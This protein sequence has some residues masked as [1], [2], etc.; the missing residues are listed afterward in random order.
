[1]DYLRKN[2]LG[3]SKRE[4]TPAV[5]REGSPISDIDDTALGTD[6]A[7]DAAIQAVLNARNSAGAATT[8]TQ[9]APA[10]A[11]GDRDATMEDTT[12]AQT[13]PVETQQQGNEE[14]VDELMDDD[15]VPLAKRREREQGP[16]TPDVEAAPKD[17]DRAATSAG[18][19]GDAS[20]TIAVPSNAANNTVTDLVLRNKNI[21]P[22]SVPAPLPL[23]VV[24]S[25]QHRAKIGQQLEQQANGTTSTTNDVATSSLAVNNNESAPKDELAGTNVNPDNGASATT[26]AATYVDNGAADV[27]L[28]LGRPITTGAN[29]DDDDDMRIVSTN[30]V[31]RLPLPP[32]E[33]PAITIIL[34]DANNYQVRFKCKPDTK[35]IKLFEA[36][37][38][39]FQCNLDHIRFISQNGIQLPKR[40]FDL[41]IAGAGLQDE[42]EIDVMLEQLGGA[43]WYK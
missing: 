25:D 17:E 7:I 22:V 16:P 42:D 21:Q 18:N 5:A 39:R 36:Y 4:T 14:E 10:N 19:G 34:R 3:A 28:P 27:N 13:G 11:V 29:D 15:D 37:A 32:A 41:T 2:L 26:L 31:P 12:Q 43:R 23:P 6:I 38:A 20:A 24:Q 8:S 30:I 1:M 35:L 33:P 9:S 40:V